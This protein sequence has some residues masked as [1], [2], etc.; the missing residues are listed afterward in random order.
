MREKQAQPSKLSE[1]RAKSYVIAAAAAGV[2]ALALA[3]P[4]DAEIVVTRKT[5]PIPDSG[6]LGYNPPTPI[7]L[8]NSSVNDF[9]FSLYTFVYHSFR[10]SLFVNTLEGGGVAASANSYPLCLEPGAKIG[11]SAHFE[12]GQF[13][14]IEERSGVNSTFAHASNHRG[15]WGGNPHDRFLGVRFLIDGATHYGWVRLNIDTLKTFSATIIEY[16]YETVP[17]QPIR[18]GFGTESSVDAG[19]GT[20][21]QGPSLGALALGTKGLAQWRH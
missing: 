16:A 7:S 1:S 5:I 3:H 13:V 19:R 15:L 18:A 20:T 14:T 10:E 12:S 11:P 6:F 2:G 17:G 4:A 8:N 9:S 21:Q